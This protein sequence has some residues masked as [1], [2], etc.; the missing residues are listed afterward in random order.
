MWFFRLTQVPLSTCC[1][2]VM[3]MKLSPIRVLQ[4]WNDSQLNT[5][6]TC[7]TTVRNPRNGK[8]YSDEFQVYDGDHVPILGLSASEAMGL[9]TV[10]EANFE[11]V[12]YIS[13]E[14]GQVF[15]KELGALPSVQ[16]LRTNP[17]I[18]P[19]VMPTRRI[20]IAVRLKLREELKRLQSLGVIQELDEPTP[21]VSQVVT[22]L[23]PLNT[24]SYAC[25]RYGPSYAC[26]ISR[27]TIV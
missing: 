9:V 19:T 8:K 18:K 20:P 25:T 4:M 7:R 11:R 27:L 17:D 1:Q 15:N 3:R 26:T 10:E 13:E 2:C 14:Y 6:G 21:W 16:H 23:N 12:S 5:L 22:T 24:S